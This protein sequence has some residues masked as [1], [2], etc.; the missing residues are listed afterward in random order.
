M[1]WNEVNIHNLARLAVRLELIVVY[2]TIFRQARSDYFFRECLELRTEIACVAKRSPTSRTKYRAA[3]RTEFFAFGTKMGWEQNGRR[4]DVAKSNE[5][6]QSNAMTHSNPVRLLQ[7]C[8]VAYP[9]L[10]QTILLF[11]S[12]QVSYKDTLKSFR[13]P[14]DVAASF[15]PHLLSLLL[16]DEPTTL[17]I[18]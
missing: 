15:K 8:S 12:Y 7:T 3:R 18:F 6:T 4:R 11:V 14:H 10:S 17:V 1:K 2:F 13:L 9:L 5:S 16:S